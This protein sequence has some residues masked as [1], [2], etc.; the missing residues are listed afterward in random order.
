M[1]RAWWHSLHLLLADSNKRKF[2]Q[3]ATNT[4]TTY[5]RIS[6]AKHTERNVIGGRKLFRYKGTT[7]KGT[8]E[9]TQYQKDSFVLKTSPSMLQARF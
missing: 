6:F 5:H 8:K 7:S 2:Q 9:C 4:I 1:L 3:K